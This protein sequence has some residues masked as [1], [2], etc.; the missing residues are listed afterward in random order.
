MAEALAAEGHLAAAQVAAEGGRTSRAA[1]LSRC[2][3]SVVVAAVSA[4][5]ME[6][7]VAEA[8]MAAAS[9]QVAPLSP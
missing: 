8:A 9:T 7:W 2:I 6:A 5:V 3:F 1:G 4:S